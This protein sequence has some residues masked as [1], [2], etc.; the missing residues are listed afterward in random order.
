MQMLLLMVKEK[1]LCVVLDRRRLQ[2]LIGLTLGESSE[3]FLMYIF[4]CY[5]NN[6]MSMILVKRL[7]T[8]NKESMQV[9]ECNI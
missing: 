2:R 3:E 1:L 5:M 9:F 4:Y 6:F 7:I 8:P